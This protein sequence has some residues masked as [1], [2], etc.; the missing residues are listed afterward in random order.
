MHSGVIERI[1]RA[2][3]KGDFLYVGLWADDMVSYYRGRKYPIV[4]LQERLL[5][6]LSCRYVDDVVI[7]A[8]YIITDT[9]I[10]SLNLSK[11]VHVVTNEDKVMKGFEDVDQF[12]VAKER[13]IYEEIEMVP[14]ELTVEKIAARVYERKETYAAKVAKKTVQQEAYLADRVK[15]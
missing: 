12:Q 7:G 2:K 4:S 15:G 1:K 5:M 9:L 13:G 6:A 14:D 11:V 10:D 3:A 8:P